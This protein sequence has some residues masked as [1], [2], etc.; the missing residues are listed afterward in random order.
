MPRKLLIAA[1]VLPL[2]VLGLGIVRAELQLSNGRRWVFDVTGYDPRDL[3]R[4]HY[5]NYRIA[6]HE[7][8]PLERCD[9]DSSQRCCL[10]LQGVAS[11]VPPKVQR[12]SCELAAKRCDG[13]LQTRYLSQL[14]RYYIPEADANKLTQRFQDAARQQRTQLLLAI[15]KS[16]KP[17]VA[18]LL[19][20]G[21]RI[22]SKPAAR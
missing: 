20:D 16:G 19:V 22:A 21:Q 14:Q 17:A 13:M 15:D 5:L 7:T 2:F 12:A 6:L 8:K 18:A 10:C 11:G 3:L 4:G 1:V 9:D